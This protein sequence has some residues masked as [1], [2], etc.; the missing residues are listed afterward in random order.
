MIQ[1]T[2]VNFAVFNVADSFA[3]IGA[4]LLGVFLLFKW[5]R[6]KA[7]QAQKE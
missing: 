3:C 6:I 7:R 2:F 5:D 4:V 1:F